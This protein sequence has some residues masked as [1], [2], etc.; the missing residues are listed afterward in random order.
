MDFPLRLIYYSAI[1]K[2]LNI[3]KKK[4]FQIGSFREELQN[5]RRLTTKQS[6]LDSYLLVNKNEH[7]D[8]PNS[9]TK[10]FIDSIYSQNS[11]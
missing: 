11:Q 5:F 7:I 1:F 2:G 8:Y 10:T 4:K 9:H 3:T 6:W